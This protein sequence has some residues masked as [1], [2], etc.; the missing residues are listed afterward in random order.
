MVNGIHLNTQKTILM[1]KNIVT[2]LSHWTFPIAMKA[3]TTSVFNAD[4]VSFSFSCTQGDLQLVIKNTNPVSVVL[5]GFPNPHDEVA[6]VLYSGSL[7]KKLKKLKKPASLPEI[8]KN[9]KI[10]LCK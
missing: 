8:P 5:T 6:M 2:E 7:D 3:T 1:S 9:R 4:E 10:N